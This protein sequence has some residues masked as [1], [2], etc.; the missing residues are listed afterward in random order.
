MSAITLHRARA[1]RVLLPTAAWL[2][3]LAGAAIAQ[4][5]FSALDRGDFP[6]DVESSRSLATADVDGDG[7]LDLVVGNG[8]LFGGPSNRLYLNDGGL[9]EDASGQ[10][11]VDT[12][13]THDIAVGDVD[14][15][16]D[17]DLYFANNS[18]GSQQQDRLYVNDGTGVFTDVTASHL[19]VLFEASTG[20]AM[21]DVDGDGDLDIVTSS[22]YGGRRQNELLL[23]DGAGVFAV[24]TAGRLPALLEPSLDVALGDVDGDGD[25][26]LVVANGAGRQNHLLLNDGAGNFSDTTATRL[27]VDASE[28]AAVA[29][30][31][32]DGDGDLDLLLGNRGY[33]APGPATPNQLY[34]N[35][36]AGFFA[37]ATST[38]LPSDDDQTHDFSVFDADA[39]GDLDFVTGNGGAN[40]LYLND[41]SGSF[42]QATGTG[43]DVDVDETAA[44]TGCDVDGDGDVDLVAVNG[45]DFVSQ[46]NR[47]YL[48]TGGATFASAARSRFPWDVRRHTGVALGDVDGD[49]DPDAFLCASGDPTSLYLND[50]DGLFVDASDALPSAP[51]LAAT[52]VA[53]ADLDG[54]GDLDA[55][56]STNDN[57]ENRL[58]RNDGT[59]RYQD[60][61]AQRL[62]GVPD[63]AT[64]I[65]IGDVDGDGDPDLVFAN[66]I[67]SLYCY[68]SLQNRLLLNDG[69]GRFAGAALPPDSDASNDVALGDLD[70]DGDLDL[71]YANSG[72]NKI[73]GNEGAGRFDEK[74][75][76]LPFRSE[77]TGVVTLGDVDGD[78]DL[79]L[80][81]GGRYGAPLRLLLNGGQGAMNDAPA[82]SLPSVSGSVL[83]LVLGD[84]D[85]DGD[86][87]LAVGRFD[88]TT[89]QSETKLLVN[90]GTG[91]FT[92]ATA[93]LRNASYASGLRLVDVDA[94]GDLDLVHASSRASTLQVNLL[95][96][97]DAPRLP[98]PG[99]AYQLDVYARDAPTS[100]VVG[101]F[102]LLSL[103][104]AAIP[105]PP[106]GVLGLD[107][108]QIAS[109]PALPIP[110]PAGVGS[111]S[112]GIPD[113]VGI[114]GTTLFSQALIV[115]FP[116]EERL[117]NVVADVI[118][119]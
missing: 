89:A 54:D 28:T 66:S 49:G 79:D 1:A 3:C 61:T 39:D 74:F 15:D 82:G 91:A 67:C 37:D 81:E 116:G 50:G 23:N 108:R 68:V 14:G 8:E 86:P 4:Q 94:D 111:L 19:P 17:V 51:F 90:D 70:G 98:R 101:A 62:P 114:A 118:V 109:L 45:A 71:V 55:V 58:Y 75:D 69:E 53:L 6:A 87:D 119:R 12:D 93:R 38:A 73:Y 22:S 32:L 29:L 95:R 43:L 60:V 106:F 80:V 72:R 102:P 20:A 107:P 44:V 33:T 13:S 24:A 26:D 57:L 85:G 117:S 78:G 2:A 40:R 10:L 47:L 7:D 48:N 63:Y 103:A 21:G 65:E 104:R 35:D 92:D 52:D 9:F 110:Q 99:R 27:P 76:W 112:F 77:T 30:A 16:G 115:R 83:S 46:P 59:G 113:V 88:S 64:A 100:G 42:A 31:D 36:G 84:V 97:L 18:P 105:L 41:G 56:M 96:Q 34:T 5:Q 11:P 25:L